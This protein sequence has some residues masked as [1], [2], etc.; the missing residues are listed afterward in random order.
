MIE[1]SIEGGFLIYFP[2]MVAWC[3]S[4]VQDG[5]LHGAD[6]AQ[7]FVRSTN[8]SISV[9][10]PLSISDPVSYWHFKNS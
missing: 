3:C 8:H 4:V 2:G 10:V 7:Y 1:S 6:I 9:S 5:G